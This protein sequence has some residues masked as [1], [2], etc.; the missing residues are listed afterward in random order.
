M[1]DL[2]EKLTAAVNTDRDRVARLRGELEAA[3]VNLQLSTASLDRAQDD[4]LIKLRTQGRTWGEVSEIMKRSESWVRGRA[5]ELACEGK[6]AYSFCDSV[7]RTTAMRNRI[8]RLWELPHVASAL[9]VARELSLAV[10]V[11]APH[12]EWLLENGRI[13]SKSPDQDKEDSSGPRRPAGGVVRPATLAELRAEVERQLGKHVL[14][15]QMFTSSVNGHR[16]VAELDLN[17]NGR[18]RMDE[19][20]HSHL[21]TE[22]FLRS[23]EKHVHELVK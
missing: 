11:V 5:L 16:H 2:I 17:G 12:L 4:H 21:V 8:A 10:E 3:K 13:R 1:L 6:L 19:S 15:A 22:Y 20:G 7:S 18:T 14:F 23:A 9:D